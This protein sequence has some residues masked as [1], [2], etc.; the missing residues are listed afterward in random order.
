MLFGLGLRDVADRIK[1]TALVEPVYPFEDGVFDGLKRSPCAGSMLMIASQTA[2][3]IGKA[4]APSCV[5][6]AISNASEAARG[7]TP[8]P[9]WVLRSCVVLNGFSIVVLPCGKD[10]YRTSAHGMCGHIRWL[11]GMAHVGL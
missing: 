2:S 7:Q 1:D 4:M 10:K 5:E 9:P 3:R 11:I 6:H 8:S